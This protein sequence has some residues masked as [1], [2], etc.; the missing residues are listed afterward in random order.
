MNNDHIKGAADKAAGAAKDALGKLTG[1]DKLRVDGAV[2]K[3]KGAAHEA[4]GDVKDAAH[5]AADRA[6]KLVDDK[7]V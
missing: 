5:M 3:A 1:D 6:R 2:D 7:K 4:I